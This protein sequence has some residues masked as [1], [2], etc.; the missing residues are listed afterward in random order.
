MKETKK[1]KKQYPKDYLE[2]CEVMYKNPV[3]NYGKCIV[4][5]N[6]GYKGYEIQTL[7]KLIFCRDAY[8][9][10]YGEEMGL[11]EPWEPDWNIRGY[12]AIAR[13]YGDIVKTSNYNCDLTFVFPTEEMRDAFYENFKEEIEICKKLL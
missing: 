3:E 6:D 13:S 8:W 4:K 11:S 12:Y 7:Q 2:C 9:K 1:D 10:L 5:I